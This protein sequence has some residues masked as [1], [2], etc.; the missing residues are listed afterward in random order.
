[1]DGFAVAVEEVKVKSYGVVKEAK[2]D[3][4]GNC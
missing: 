1:M 3:L 4:W 2:D